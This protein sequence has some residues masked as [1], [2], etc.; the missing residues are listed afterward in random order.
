V[1]AK[2]VIDFFCPCKSFG[3]EQITKEGVRTE[4]QSP[5]GDF[6]PDIVA[7]LQRAESGDI[8]IF[9]QIKTACTPKER[10]RILP[11]YAFYI[12]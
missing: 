9:K 3:L 11:N 6:N 8:Y 2:D 7:L 5:K 1:A 12:Q 4:A 10:I